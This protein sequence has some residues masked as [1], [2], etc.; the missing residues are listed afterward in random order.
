MANKVERDRI[1]LEGIVLE[2][3]KNK[4]KVLVNDDY[5]VSCTLSG[6]IRQNSVKILVDDRVLL[7][8]SVY[9]T[10]QGRI[11]YRLKAD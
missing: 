3:N 2:A 7:E 5:I 11:I 8:V 6:K 4:F 9:D 10:L 1:E